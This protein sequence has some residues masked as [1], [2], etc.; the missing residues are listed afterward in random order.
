M[1]DYS[2][3]IIVKDQ[4]LE[5]YNHYRGDYTLLSDIFWGEIEARRIIKNQTK[6]EKFKSDNPLSRIIINEDEKELSIDIGIP[7]NENGEGLLMIEKYLDLLRANWDG[8]KITYLTEGFHD[9]IRILNTYNYFED[10]CQIERI[11]NYSPDYLKHVWDEPKGTL[12]SIEMDNA[13]QYEFKMENIAEIISKGTA[14]ISEPLTNEISDERIPFGGIHVNSDLKTVYVWYTIETIKLKEW[15]IGFWPG[16]QIQFD[17]FGYRKHF[18]QIGLEGKLKEIENKLKFNVVKML[19]EEI[20]DK[21]DE[22]YFDFPNRT[23]KFRPRRMDKK[24]MINKFE[25]L[26]YE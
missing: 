18:N 8:W 15:I 26:L 5:I 11:N 17:V 21:E 24:L 23:Y 10:D 7:E 25:K 14:L 19:N 2:E 6:S 3:Y 22:P 4:K 16:W 13:I 1:P 9:V 20:I 12:L